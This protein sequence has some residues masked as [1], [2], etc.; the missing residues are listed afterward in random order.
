MIEVK[1]ISKIYLNH[2]KPFKALDNISLTIGQGDYLTVTGPSGS[3]KSTLLYALGGLVRPDSGSVNYR[4]NNIYSLSS[5]EKNRYRRLKTG[6]VF[7]QFHL[8]PYLTVLDNIRMACH[9]ERHFDRIDS[10][11]EECDLAGLKFKYPSSLSVGEKQRAAFIRAIV[12]EP[13]ILLADEPTGNLDGNNSVILME[14]IQKYHSGGGTV[15][16]VSHNP[17]MRNH[18]SGLVSLEKGRIVEQIKNS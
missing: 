15:V 3:G 6:F 10:L 17:G 8:V 7:Q 5:G 18:A 11:L 16:V 9:E 1:N 14:M 12:S 2:G 13:E 4:G